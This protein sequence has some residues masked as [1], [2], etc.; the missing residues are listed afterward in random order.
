MGSQINISIKNNFILL[1]LLLIL[2]FPQTVS[3]DTLDILLDSNDGSSGFAIKDSGSTEMTHMDSDGNIVTKGCVRI[4]AGGIKCADAE[5]L[6]IDGNVGIG[7][8]VPGADLQIVGGDVWL[9]NGTFDN[10]SANEDLYVT[11]NI[12]LDGNFYL[13]GTTEITG[14][15]TQDGALIIDETNIEALLVRQNADADDVFIVDTTNGIVK[16]EGPTPQLTIGDA[17]AEDT[18]LVYDGNAQDFYIGIDDD[19]DDLTIGTGAAVGTNALMVVENNGNVGLG[20]TVP[21]AVLE[22]IENGV[23]PFMVSNGVGGVGNFMIVTTAGNVGI[24]T[25]VPDAIVTVDQTNPEA[26]LVRQDANA[27]DIF[28]IDTTNSQVEIYDQ[29]GIGGTPAGGIEL[30]VTGDIDASGEIEANN[31]DVDATEVISSGRAL[32]NIT[33]ANIDNVQIDGNT[34]NA[35]NDSGLFLYD[36]DTNGIVISDAGN[37]G[38]GTTTINALLVV[39]SGGSLDNVSAGDAYIKNDLEVDGNL[40]VT[41]DVSQ[42]GSSSYSEAVT[43]DVDHAESL[44]VRKDGDADD[45]FIVD[46][47]DGVVKVEGPTPQLTIGDADAE[48]TVLVYDGNAQDFY[49]GIDDDTDDLTIGTGAAVGTNALMVVENNGNVGLGTTIPSATLEIVEAGTT[50][51][52]IS[53]GV[54]ADGDFVIVTTAGNVGISTTVPD[55]IVTVDQTNPE[56]FLV[57]QDAN[58]KDIFLVDT[59]N[60]QVELYD[61]LGIGGTPAGGIELDVTGDIDASGEIE[62]NNFDVDATEVIS[63]ARALTNITAATIDSIAIDGTTVGHTGD[64]D[65]LTFAAGNLT[66]AGTLTTGNN[67]IDG[68]NYDMSAAGALTGISVDVSGEVQAN[69]VD[70]DGTDVIS[71]A[72]ALTNITAATIDNVQVDG[73]TVNATTATGLFLYEDGSNG[74]FIRDGGNVGVGTTTVDALLVVGSGGSLDNVSAGDAYIKNDLE[75]D[76]NLY[77]TG[78]VTQT[79]TSSYDEAVTID[80]DN[81]EALLVRKNG[82]GGDIFLIDTTNSQAELYSQLGIGGTPAGGIE[83]DV[84]GDIDASGEIEANNFDIDGTEVI[85]SAS[86]LT[87]I[88][89]ATIDS[90][91][92]DGTTI[93]HTADTD[94]LTLAAGNLTLA[95]TLTTGNNAIDGTNYDMSAA[96]ALTGVSVDVSGEVQANNVDIDGTDVISA[97][98][99]LTNITA[100]NIDNI[101]ID[102]NTINATNDSGLLLYD[103][104]TNGIVIA[105]AGNVGIGTTTI[106]ALLVVGSGGSLDNVAAGDAYIKND[107]EVDGNLYV[108]GSVTQ[109]GTSSYDEAVT[110][111]LDNTEAL[112]VRKN[113]DGG[114]ILLVDT[115]NSQVEL[116]SQLGIGGTPAGGIELDVTGDI[117]ASGEIE[118]N[119]FD[120]DGTEVISAAMALTNITAATI[121]SIA[122][123][124]ATIGHTADA[125]LLTLAADNLTLAGTLTTGNNAIDGTNYDMSAAGAL[126]GVSVDVSGEVQANNFDVDA[127]EVISAARALT[128]ITAATVDNVQIDGNTVNAT[129]AAGLFLYEDGSNGMFIRDGGNV[130]IGTTTVDALLVIGSG[131]SLDNVAAGDVYIKN[132]LEVDGNIYFAGGIDTMGDDLD[133]QQNEILNIG[134]NGTDFTDTGGLTLADALTVS[135]NGANITGTFTI[136]ANEIEDAEVDDN[137]TIS[138]GT[139]GS[140]DISGTLT[141]TGALTIG[142]NGDDVIISASDWD[143]DASGNITGVT[144]DVSGEIEANNFDVDATEVISAAR[145]LTN[146]TAATVDNVQIDGNTVNATTAAGLFLYEDGS[147]GIFIKD[148]GN[149]GIGSTSPTQLLDVSNDFTVTAAGAVVAATLDTGQGANELYDMDQNVL[150]ASSPTFAGLTVTNAINEFSTDGNLAG[151]SDSALP[152]E[153]AVKTYVDAQMGGISQDSITEGN[154]GVEVIDAGA[155]GRVVF[156]T[157]GAEEMRITAAGNVGIGSTVPSSILDVDG[158]VT[159]T[160]FSGSGSGLTGLTGGTVIVSYRL[161]GVLL[162]KTNIDGGMYIPFAGTVVSVSLYR[163]TAGSSGSTLVDIHKNGTTVFTTQ[164][165]RPTLAFGAGQKVTVTNMDV[166]SVSAGDVFTCDVDQIDAGNPEDVIVVLELEKS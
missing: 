80:I 102:A 79:G 47:I 32:T 156:T 56:A 93:G 82:D 86:A 14:S 62:A 114:D 152:T 144:V 22:I 99:A 48:D 76:G 157:E 55:A 109:T 97:A 2:I 125:D 52:M 87:N 145:A 129:T 138:S 45:V 26:F 155:D 17:D 158:T 105:D 110:I 7:T 51:F 141:T 61:Q 161:M 1:V 164:G 74:M 3:A 5:N 131:G 69:N 41:G 160:T 92:I 68:T 11:G 27:K 94:L 163:G 103:N 148:G 4:D 12:E 128:N 37:V 107:L 111:D 123:D 21:N 159:A 43:I 46:T 42:T 6:I 30:D 25:T 98:R 134:V 139:I 153:K 84:T 16:I 117:D 165:N 113:G 8:T 10:A 29:L 53:N 64:T 59:T 124:G 154:T 147:N 96:G 121:D 67:A 63:A 116:Y 151:D 54:A 146:I 18:V 108:T 73:N 49:I 100:A 50:P 101:Q 112:L 23:V 36:N 120:I 89:A 65:L 66:L 40:Y 75:V 126:T 77:V 13:T 20:T 122:I 34:I 127:T 57:R 58:A 71:A 9:G 104:D 33:A 39:G 60:S 78:S 115:T 137:I 119:N 38:I 135:A 143:V 140:N 162:A 133:M 72:R 81:T 88:T 83:L 150:Q 91:A 35:T 44:L 70:I 106:N 19:T 166:T 85:S 132:D 118:A 149:V 95:G 90:I 15:T 28:L 130:G 142:D 136:E 24:S 31:F